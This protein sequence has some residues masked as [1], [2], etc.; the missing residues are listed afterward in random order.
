M[1]RTPSPDSA[2]RHSSP[3]DG[4]VEH[5]ATKFKGLGSHDCPQLSSVSSAATSQ[6]GTG[7]RGGSQSFLENGSPES[8][9]LVNCGG[10]IFSLASPPAPNWK[11]PTS[12]QNNKDPSRESSFSP[13]Q[14]VTFSPLGSPQTPQAT[15]TRKSPTLFSS[16]FVN[17]E[18][19]SGNQD[20]QPFQLFHNNVEAVATDVAS[21]KSLSYKSAASRQREK[22]LPRSPDAGAAH[23]LLQP[24]GKVAEDAA[25]VAFG[26]G[27]CVEKTFWAGLSAVPPRGSS[28]V[29][30]EMADVSKTGATGSGLTS[31]V[32]GEKDV[33]PSVLEVRD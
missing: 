8:L 14:A 23:G 5:L 11:G 18:G 32:R 12:W 24:A 17:L 31:A 1:S 6:G 30:D 7:P 33:L 29:M 26:N 10:S 22:S 15:S 13:N 19:R 21:R 4:L 28:K 3:D 16:D 2:G 27:K 20:G 9:L 25:A